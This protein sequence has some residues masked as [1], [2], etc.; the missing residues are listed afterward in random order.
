LDDPRDGGEGLGD[1]ELDLKGGVAGLRGKFADVDA[2]EPLG[3]FAFDLFGFEVFADG[4]PGVLVGF[5]GRVELRP[6]L[7]AE[8]FA[9]LLFFLGEGLAGFV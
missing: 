1:V 4:E 3:G 7:L 2:A 5:G 9:A 8:D 6:E